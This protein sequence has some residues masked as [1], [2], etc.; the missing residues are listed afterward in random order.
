[1]LHCKSEYLAHGEK[2]SEK[3]PC[4]EM[5]ADCSKRRD[6]RLR[7]RVVPYYTRYSNNEV[8]ELLLSFVNYVV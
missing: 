7:T 8:T 6:H 3:S 5:M 4:V 2:Q 1:M